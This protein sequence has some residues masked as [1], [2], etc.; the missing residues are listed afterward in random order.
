MHD[1]NKKIGLSLGVVLKISER[2]NI[3]CRYC[4]FFFGGDD[5]YKKNPPYI[6][7]DTVEKIAFFLKKGCLDL[8]IKKLSI[9]LHGGEPLMLKIETFDKI[10]NTFLKILSPVVKLQFTLQTNA[11]LI[12][13]D[14]ISVFK[15]YQIGVGVSID[16]PKEYNDIDR[17]DKLGRGTHSK[18]ENGIKLLQSSQY[19]VG[20]ITVINPAFDPEKIYRYFVDDLKFTSLAFSLPHMHHDSIHQHPPE[21]YGEFLCEL[22]KIW[23][24]DD[25]PKIK[26]RC[27]EGAIDTLL[28]GSSSV[29]GIGKNKNIGM[30]DGNGMHLIS[31]SSSG[32][33][34]P[35]DELRVTESKIMYGDMLS[36]DDISLKNFF[37]LP[38]FSQ[39]NESIN[40]VS[41]DCRKCVWLNA[42]SGG[43]LVSRFSSKNGFNNKS[44]YCD[45][46]KKYYS[47]VAAF[48][49]KNG[50][51]FNTIAGNI[52]LI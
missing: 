46:L 45:G 33:L 17:I 5:S 7:L 11:M 24:Q 47:L 37:S 18:V 26:I 29:Y 40:D 39:L 14:W 2:C 8:G 6:T 10:C 13:E 3:A 32:I 49:V 36:I 27:F 42:C 12:S 31:I 28:G 15:K 52:G 22:F 4:Y 30:E 51:D 9:G 48:L 25:N 23:I 1:E 16:G 50:Y 41:D 38:L 44:I 20:S 19:P 34:S 35:V 21:L 43:T